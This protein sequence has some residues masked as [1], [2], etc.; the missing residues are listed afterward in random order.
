MSLTTLLLYSQSESG[1]KVAEAMKQ[2]R[3]DDYS[4]YGLF[5]NLDEM[6]QMME[7]MDMTEHLKMFK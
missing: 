1:K 3:L 2:Q 4:M 5:R 6:E 7:S